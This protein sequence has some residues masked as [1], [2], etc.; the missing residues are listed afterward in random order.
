MRKYRVNFHFLLMIHSCTFK[1]Q[2]ADVE[3]ANMEQCIDEIR[4]WIYSKKRRLN[5]SK[6]QF[7]LVG[8][9]SDIEKAN[10]RSLDIG[11]IKVSPSDLARNLCV[12]FDKELSGCILAARLKVGHEKLVFSHAL[13]RL[14]S[15]F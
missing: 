7:L 2:N 12:I 14:W 13:K 15:C 1:P 5:D 11:E 4:N 8:K 6:T 10:L 3:I 9:S